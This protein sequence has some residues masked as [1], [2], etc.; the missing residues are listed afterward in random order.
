MYRQYTLWIMNPAYPQMPWKYITSA[1]ARDESDFRDMNS[2]MMSS[3]S[4][5][6]IGMT[7][8]NDEQPQYIITFT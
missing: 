3:G 6:Y 7:G 1:S 2:H 8:A 5:E 4:P